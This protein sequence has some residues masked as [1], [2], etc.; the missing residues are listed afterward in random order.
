MTK[1]ESRTLLKIRLR[2]IVLLVILIAITL[3]LGQ[4]IHQLRTESTSDSYSYF[5]G[6]LVLSPNGEFL[7]TKHGLD[8]LIIFDK[9]LNVRAE[10]NL[11]NEI[12]EG[13]LVQ[14]DFP[15]DDILTFVYEFPA[16]DQGIHIYDYDLRTGALKERIRFDFGYEFSGNRWLAELDSGNTLLVYGMDRELTYE[17]EIFGSNQSATSVSVQPIRSERFILLHTLHTLYSGR[18]SESI[19]N[20][21]LWDLESQTG[22]WA[23]KNV[24]DVSQSLAMIARLHSSGSD[25]WALLV[26][27]NEESG[28]R[29]TYDQ[30]IGFLAF[31]L[32]DK[33]CAIN[34]NRLRFGQQS[35]QVEILDAENGT[36]IKRL[37]NGFAYRGV[38]S[39]DTSILYLNMAP[40]GLNQGS[41]IEA[42]DWKNERLLH[43]CGNLRSTWP[44]TWMFWILFAAWGFMHFFYFFD[45]KKTLNSR[46]DTAI[47]AII[48]ILAFLVLANQIRL[49]FHWIHPWF[50]DDLDLEMLVASPAAAG[51]LAISLSRVQKLP[52]LLFHLASQIALLATAWFLLPTDDHVGFFGIFAIHQ[53]LILSLITG[54]I[55]IRIRRGMLAEPNG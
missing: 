1:P 21:Q 36:R 18:G 45:R 20:Y 46:I 7:V 43:R 32:D 13:S 33:L 51:L 30:C 54:R 38:F 3:A 23:K 50:Y 37:R 6:P 25:F 41:L 4:T 52:A 31:S 28:K 11:E 19:R 5:S 9:E 39:P 10:I 48:T 42:W 24:S 34:T 27:D 14:Y 44:E 12:G 40:R 35:P 29:W 16:S 15:V 8:C 49:V 26:V 53:G 17:L 47:N 2:Q 22:V 55:L